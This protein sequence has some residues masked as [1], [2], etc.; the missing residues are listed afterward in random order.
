[1]TQRHFVASNHPED[2]ASGRIFE[3]GDWAVGVDPTDSYDHAKIA[4]GRLVPERSNAPKATEAAEKRAAEL[5]ID[6]STVVGTG[7]GGQIKVSDLESAAPANP[8]EE[9]SQ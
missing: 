5:G 9:E 1:M 7:A 2:I 6:L 4:A 8:N 3:P